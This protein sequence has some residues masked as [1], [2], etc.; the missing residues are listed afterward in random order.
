MISIFSSNKMDEELAFIKKQSKIKLAQDSY[1]KYL[2]H[3]DDF[4]LWLKSREQ[5]R[6]SVFD[7]NEVVVR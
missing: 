4:L 3:E 6:N 2:E 7:R 1:L 5:G